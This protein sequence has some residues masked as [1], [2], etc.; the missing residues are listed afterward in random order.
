MEALFSDYEDVRNSGLFDAEYYLVTYPD[1]AERNIDPLVH[2]LEEGVREGRNPYRGFDARFYLEQCRQRGEQPN[3]PLLHYIR[4]GAARGFKTQ[5]EE[6]D[7]EPAAGKRPDATDPIGKLPILVAIES[8]GVVGVPNGT[9][10]LSVG[11][12]A[13]AET[14]IVEIIVSIDDEA[15]GTAAYGLARPDIARLYPERAA[16]P[17]CGFILALD[18][19]G[20]TSGA[21]EPLLTVRTA[22]GEIGQRRLRVAIPPQTMAGEAVDPDRTPDVPEISKAPMQLAID[23]ATVDRNGILRAGGWVLCVVQIESVEAFID[24]ARIGKA[25]FGRVRGDIEKLHPDY[26]NSRFSGFALIVDAGRY[27]SGRKTIAIKATARSGIVRVAT[28]QVE[29]PELPA[30]GPALQDPGFRYHFEEI[31]LT[32][33]GRIA[34]CGW[35]VCRSP[36]AAVIVLLDGEEIGQAELGLERPDLG[37]LFPS[38]AHARQP[39]FGYAAKMG[40]STK[41]GFRSS[42]PSKRG[43]AQRR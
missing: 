39:G 21:I 1:V 26:P 7:H 2:Y 20:P 30:A 19:P 4:I 8:L 32:P 14:P 33:T 24:G 38:L 37:N 31:A 23:G 25:E 10:R 43:L 6:A 15:V 5:R 13:L 9:S 29:I 42:P 18:L 41:P 16:A 17:R 35:T 28:A 11:G 27:G 3:N 36:A 22:D 12:W 34:V 40:K